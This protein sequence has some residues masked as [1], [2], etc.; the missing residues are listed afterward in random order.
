MV[1]LLDKK[2]KKEFIERLMG[3]L[4]SLI[5][6]TIIFPCLQH[7]ARQSLAAATQLINAGAEA[8]RSNRNT[9][10]QHQLQQSSQALDDQVTCI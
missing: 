4:N 5:A 10:S 8:N 6:W 3:D 1:F 7:A 2:K 9:A